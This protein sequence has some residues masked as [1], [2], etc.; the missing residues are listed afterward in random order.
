M[1]FK[2]L[3]LTLLLLPFSLPAAVQQDNNEAEVEA[4]KFRFIYVAPDNNMSQQSLITDLT[5]HYNH[6]I[7]EE[8]SAIFYLSFRPEPVIVRFN[9]GKDDNPDDFESELLY[10]LRQTMS[11]N[12]APD[13]DRAR[14]M[15]I[16][17]ENSYE[18]ED[19]VRKY[20]DIEL[21][22]HVGKTFWD[23]SNN[24]SIIAPV[25][26]Y[27]DAAKHIADKT[28]QFNVMFHCPPSKGTFNRDTPFGTMNPD[29]I[30]Q[31]VIPRVTD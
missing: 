6:I 8:S 27:L 7:S 30:N 1:K 23:S 29:N 2:Y 21:D 26:F 14:I 11:Y 24:E 19:G 28:M 25:F 5:D 10:T 18:D 20:S 22:F 17:D 9:T 3:L 15:E 4:G 13:Y 16:M 31:I 12:V